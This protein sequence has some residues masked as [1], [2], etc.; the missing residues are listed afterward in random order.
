VLFTIEQFSEPLFPMPQPRRARRNRRQTLGCSRKRPP[1]SALFAIA[2][3]RSRARRSIRAM[4]R[5]SIPLNPL[6]L[7]DDGDSLDEEKAVTRL[8]K[9]LLPPPKRQRPQQFDRPAARPKP[10]RRA[11]PPKP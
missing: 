2:H 5:Q 3:L 7:A 9:H 8:S 1:G 10:A 6:L 11:N 4:V